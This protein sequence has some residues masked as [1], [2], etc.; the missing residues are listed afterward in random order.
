[1]LKHFRRGTAAG[2]AADNTP[3]STIDEIQNA[4]V[5]PHGLKMLHDEANSIVE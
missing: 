5:S 4:E 1:M 2:D 3:I